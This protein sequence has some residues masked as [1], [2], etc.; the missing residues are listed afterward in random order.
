MAEWLN[1][2]SPSFPRFSEHCCVLIFL[3]S[4]VF[5]VHT[6][7]KCEGPFAQKKRS[8]LKLAYVGFLIGSRWLPF[9]GTDFCTETN[10]TPQHDLQDLQMVAGGSAALLVNTH[11]RMQCNAGRVQETKGSHTWTTSFFSEA[12][13]ELATFVISHR[14][15]G[16]VGARTK[17]SACGPDAHVEQSGA[18]KLCGQ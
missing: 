4:D 3:F 15:R 1:N 14:T 11:S 2:S 17:H 5:V 10:E 16:T 9:R 13:I 12:T 7:K 8:R 18:A 6:T